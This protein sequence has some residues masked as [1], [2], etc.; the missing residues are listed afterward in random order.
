MNKK[1]NLYISKISTY[2]YY[3]TKNICSLI[4]TD[5]DF[6]INNL[7]L[8]GLTNLNGLNSLDIL[9]QNKKFDF[10]KKI[11][12]IDI[13]ILNV[14]N[15]NEISLLKNILNYDEMYD[16]LLNYLKK[17]NAL[18]NVDN[19]IMIKIINYLTEQNFDFLEKITSSLSKFYD[20]VIF[21]IILEIII[22]FNKC[23]LNETYKKEYVLFITILCKYIYNDKI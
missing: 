8:L 7:F 23:C 4:E 16:F 12:N 9:L 3:I 21:N 1:I 15:S 13:E 20:N 22:I 11:I 5:N 19:K 17:I 2:D 14:K 18:K 10:I 6:I